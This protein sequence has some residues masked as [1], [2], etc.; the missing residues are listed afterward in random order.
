MRR[1]T[2][3]PSTKVGSGCY[4]TRVGGTKTKMFLDASPRTRTQQVYAHCAENVAINYSSTCK[5]SSGSRLRCSVDVAFRSL[6]LS[7]SPKTP[8]TVKRQQSCTEQI[9]GPPKPISKVP[10]LHNNNGDNAQQGDIQTIRRVLLKTSR[11][12]CAGTL[13]LRSNRDWEIG[14]LG[15]VSSVQCLCRVRATVCICRLCLQTGLAKKYKTIGGASKLN[16][17]MAHKETPHDD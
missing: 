15:M 16:S 2:I 12:C 4:R 6:S 11:D 8:T 3:I 10:L 13:L 5:R 9:E 7:L 14:P 17:D 1:L